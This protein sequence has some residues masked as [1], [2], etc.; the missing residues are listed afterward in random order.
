MTK[1]RAGLTALILAVFSVVMLASPAS[2]DD[3]APITRYHVDVN[4]TPQGVA[5]VKIDFTMDFG[6][7]RG[8][9]PLIILPTRQDDGANPD[10]QYV[11]EYSNF[12]VSSP[13]GASSRTS[14]E[15]DAGGIL[16]RIGDENRWNTTAQEYVLEYDVTGFIVSD[17]AQSGLDEFNWNVI[18]PAWDSSF[19]DIQVS[20]TG[21]V[22]VSGAACFYG[23]GYTMECEASSS[24]QTAQYSHSAL[25]PSEPMQVVAGFPAGTFGG[26]EQIKTRKVTAAN[27]FELTP[28]TG[29]IAGAGILAAIAGLFAVQR[30]HARDDVYL[31]LTPGLVPKPGE[32]S[33]VGPSPKKFP[34]AVQFNPPKGATPGEI[35]TL[36]DTTAD[37]VDVSATIVD[38]AVRGYL[39]IEADGKRDF[40]LHAAS[41]PRGD[42]LVDYEATLLADLFKGRPSRHSSELRKATFQNVLPHAKEGLYA[43]VVRKGWFKSN[44]NGSQV[45]PIVGGGLLIGAGVMAAMFLASFGWGLISLPLVVLGVGLIAISGKFRKRTAQGSA[46]LAQAKGFELYLRT[47]EKETLRFEEGEDIFSK[48]LPYAIV[49]GVADRWSKLFAQLG[50]EGLYQADTSWYIGADLMHGYYFASAMNNLTHSFNDVMNAARMDGMSQ[51]TGGSSGFSGF[52]GG[53]GFGGGG[54]GSW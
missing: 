54:G 24:G 40:V 52:S 31:G 43:S 6:Q 25:Q 22:D 3:A 12:A 17:Q 37:N 53:G 39:R 28:V 5:Q 8:R 23:R 36:L 35:G 32:T 33:N 7:F 13:S 2:A 44:P 38:L 16:L 42:K 26:V 4:L 9:G 51:A 20:V 30:R 41:A 29:G 19:Q 48:Y 49:F 50:A 11:F 15:S 18:G 34:V 27:A 1:L 14:R 45:L 21:P 47:A 10:E 46:Y